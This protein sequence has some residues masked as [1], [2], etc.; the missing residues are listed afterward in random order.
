ME[1]DL[2]ATAKSWPEDPDTQ[3]ELR[4]M[5]ADLWATAETWPGDLNTQTELW[6]TEADLKGYSPIRRIH[7]LNVGVVAESQEKELENTVF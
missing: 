7:K 4:W 3:T 5:E 6:G 2:S 1:A